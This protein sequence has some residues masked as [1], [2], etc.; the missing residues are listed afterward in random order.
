MTKTNY[1]VL[2]AGAVENHRFII[3][4]LTMLSISCFSICLFLRIP[5]RL[6]NLLALF[7]SCGSLITNCVYVCIGLL[8]LRTA[9]VLCAMSQDSVLSVS[10]RT[11]HVVFSTAGFKGGG[12]PCS[13]TLETAVLWRGIQ[14]TSRT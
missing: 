13:N 2:S 8:A 9:M 12:M 7:R 3:D 1:S 11:V 14:K 6:S 4:S 5:I 10:L